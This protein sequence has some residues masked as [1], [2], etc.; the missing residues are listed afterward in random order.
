MPSEKATNSANL[1][2]IPVEMGVTMSEKSSI[3]VFS[4]ATV[5][6][7]SCGFDVLGF[8]LE[9]PGDEIVL[10]RAEEPGIRI[11]RITGDGGCL[12][13]EPEQN[14]AGAALQAMVRSMGYSG[15]LEL[16]IHKKM[17]VQS[18]LGSS[19][20]SAA[21]AVF[22]ANRLLGCPF[23]SAD[24]VP[25]A[26][27]GERAACGTAHAD[28][29]APALLGGFVIVRSRFPLDVVPI[30]APPSLICTVFSPEIQISTAHS[31]RILRQ[32]IDLQEAV[33][34]WGN[35]A[36]LIAA[37]LREDYDLLSRSLQDR[38]VEPIRARLIPGFVQ[39]K[40]AAVEAGALG[41]GISGSGPSVFA[42]STT[43][44]TARAVGR[45]LVRSFERYQVR[46]TV[47][48]SKINTRG[49]VIL[50]R[51]VS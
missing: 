8:A 10:K 29:V 35:L 5:A 15:G 30:G 2:E 21:G 26:M 43:L 31:R 13:K 39:A 24:L 28:N 40:K 1:G 3:R 14:A 45:V 51:G 46:G 27:E 6:N 38:I 37:L 48:V 47:Y 23:A 44:Q 16:E 22:A 36:A 7:V 32:R 18:G 4:P 33:E 41:A 19:A 17:P 12:P 20:A 50:G 34:Q 42:L 49:P 9:R 25:F 11:T